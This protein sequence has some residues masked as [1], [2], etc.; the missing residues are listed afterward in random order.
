M[1]KPI[2]FW[3]A[4]ASLEEVFAELSRQ[5]GVALRFWPAQTEEPRVPV[6][7]F[8]NPEK[9]PSLREVMAQLMWVTGGA[10]AWSEAA[11]GRAY[12]LLSTSAGR[13]AAERLAA[14]QQAQREQFRSA[15]E[16][17]Q[18][19]V[20][21]AASSQL[22]KSKAALALSEGEAIARY[23]GSNDALLLDLLDPSRRA[24]LVLLTSLPAEDL[25]QLFGGS[26]GVT[27][28]WSAWSPDRQAIIRQALAGDDDWPAEVTISI[29]LGRGRGEEGATVTASRP[30]R[31]RRRPLGRVTGLL[32][33]GDLRGRDQIALLRLAGE[34]RTPEQAEAARRQ[35]QE[36]QRQAR[37]D[38]VAARQQE[39]AER[40]EQ[41]LASTRDLSP[42]AT[43]LLASLSLGETD[44]GTGFWE[45]QQAVAKATGLH[46][47]SDCF[48]PPRFGGP[49]RRGRGAGAEAASALEALSAASAPGGGW[50]AAAFG[51][52]AAGGRRGP[53]A[54][55]PPSPGGGGPGGGT[56]GDLSMLW[57]DAGRFLRFRTRSPEIW[58]GALLPSDVLAQLDAW[59]EPAVKAAAPASARPGD[60]PLS[61]DLEKL[62]W[63]AGRLDDLQARLG[64]AIPYED[65]SDEKAARRQG[66]RRATLGL[67]SSRLPLL[68]LLATLTPEQWAS[69]RAEGLRW[70]YDL[71]PDQQASEALRMLTANLPSERISDIVIKIGQTEA[72]T[73]TGRDGTEQTIPPVPAI[74]FSL[75]GETVGQIPTAGG[76][77]GPGGRSGGFGA[78]GGR[79][80]PGGPP[81]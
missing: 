1:E 76:F 66:L 72:R 10:F 63:L 39:F 57:G 62:C 14:Q 15:R 75:D 61:G 8:L 65:P 13:G 73:F 45:L 50:L 43:A 49:G 25:D 34:V 67:V 74:T 9:P 78:R 23:R 20:R 64:G 42:T 69:V 36:T 55:G 33:T 37:Q 71:T 38:A 70:G 27:R 5:T 35:Q 21:E 80:G 3:R 48:W 56:L 52:G 77:G 31:Q 47:V 81:G 79:G 24:A 29:S 22:E 53:G 58:R 11:D 2:R 68:R 40:R 12:Y 18:E 32:R 7:L 46:V 6:T 30:G 26:G 60:T 16:A 44:G 51:G 41:A 54:G 28:E 17:R 4:G 59:L 19:S